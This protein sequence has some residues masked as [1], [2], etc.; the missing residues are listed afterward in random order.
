MNKINLEIYERYSNDLTRL[1]KNFTESSARTTEVMQNLK[2]FIENSSAIVGG[3]II[4]NELASFIWCYERSFGGTKRLH[5][6]YFI[7]DEKYRGQGLSKD[8]LKFSQEEARKLNIQLI[9][10]NVEPDNE[11]AIKVYKKSGFNTEKLQL[12]M[13]INKDDKNV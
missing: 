11:T 4:D 6:S 12:V 13:E 9:D 1:I 7:V 5:I 10:L 2:S 8:L 3:H